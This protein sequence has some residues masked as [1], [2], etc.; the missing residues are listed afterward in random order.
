M[1][2]PMNK[3][4]FRIMWKSNLPVQSIV[5]IS[6]ILPV[7]ISHIHGHH[8]LELSGAVLVI[9]RKGRAKE[10]VPYHLGGVISHALV[11]IVKFFVPEF[12]FFNAQVIFF[13]K[14]HVFIKSLLIRMLLFSVEKFEFVL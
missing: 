12:T 5:D 8:H 11:F 2:D 1:P 7:Y 14:I 9:V 13:I 6:Y 10:A 4:V 3:Y